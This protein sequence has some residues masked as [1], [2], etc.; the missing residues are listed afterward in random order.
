[1]IENQVRAVVKYKTEVADALKYLTTKAAPTGALSFGG[2]MAYR[3]LDAH[4]KREHF[5]A[6]HDIVTEAAASPERLMEA[7][8]PGMGKL[9]ENDMAAASQYAATV[10]AHHSYL[11][12]QMPQSSDPLMGPEDFSMDEMEVTLEQAGALESIP[13]VIA[14]AKD[15]SVTVEAV[16]AIRTV[17]PAL[18]ADAVLDIADFMGSPEWDKLSETARLGLDTFCGGA[19][20]VLQSYGPMPGVLAAQTPFQHQLLGTNPQQA[21]PQ[22]AA[23]QGR[24]ASTSGQKVEAL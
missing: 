18:Y 24:M 1:M 17:M 6:I 8:T 20:G 15:G 5:A 2:V 3:T 11:L 16:D 21:N 14:T 4:S 7:I 22:M 19:L 13:S 9:A 23:Q 12:Q 10:V